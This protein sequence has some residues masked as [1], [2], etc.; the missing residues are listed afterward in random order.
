MDSLLPRQPAV[1]SARLG[2]P[3][4]MRCVSEDGASRGHG[5]VSGA[6]VGAVGR[7]SGEV[8][9]PEF[10]FGGFCLFARGWTSGGLV[11]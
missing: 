4:R 11:G 9:F 10:F 1:G 2:S 5:D 3:G 8:L 7:A 6:A